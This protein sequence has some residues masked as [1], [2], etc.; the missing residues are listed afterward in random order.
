[1]G[2]YVG[3]KLGKY[4]L[5]R[6]LG[7]GS[8]ADVYL[9]RPLPL[10]TEYAVKVL[11]TQMSEDNTSQFFDQAQLIALLEHT[12][13]LRL[14]DF[15]V[16][17]GSPFLVMD[18]APYGTLR[19]RHP[20]G[21][22][23]PLKTILHY[24]KQIAGALQYAHDHELIHL[25][26][27]P[28]NMMLGRRGEVLLSDFGITPI[29]QST[30]L[31]K[32][33]LVTGTAAYMSPEQF[34]GKVCFA[35]DQYALGIVV[36]EWLSGKCPFRGSFSEVASQ[37]WSALPPSLP[38]TD[39]TVP[40]AVEDVVM[41]AL[42][43]D[44]GQRFESVQDFARALTEAGSSISSLA[45]VSTDAPTFPLLP[46]ITAASS[47]VPQPLHARSQ[48]PDLPTAS[49]PSGI[50][51]ITTSPTET[52][53]HTPSM[54]FTASTHVGQLAHY[55]Q[56]RPDTHR[57]PIHP[58]SQQAGKFSA[59]WHQLFHS[60]KAASAVLLMILAIVIIAGALTAYVVKLDKTTQESPAP[61][62]IGVSQ[63]P[64]GEY[65]GI[66]DGT[67]AFDTNRADG[68]SKRE[69]ADKLKV[70][71]ITTAESL[72]QIGIQHDANDAEALIYQEDQQVLS[73]DHPHITLVVGTVLT[74]TTFGIGTGREELQG[75]YIAQKEFNDHAKL[76]G[77]IQV[78]LLIANSGNQ[79]EYATRVA[80]QIVQ[81]ARVD[82]TIVGVM[83]WP[84]NASSAKAID[85]LEASHIPMISPTAYD[86]SL[87]GISPYFFRVVPP[88]QRQAV[89]GAQF[90]E[91]RFHSKRGAL[92]VDPT[93]TYSKN[94]AA[95]FEQQFV[96]DGN[97]IA[98]TEKYTVGQPETLPGLLQN[99]LGA[100][101]DLIYFAGYADD[102]G[103][104]LAHLPTSGPFANIQ[105]LGGEALYGDYHE[106]TGANL[107]R[108]HFTASAYS[109]EWD[110]LN[111]SAKKPP[112]FT[113]FEQDFP[114]EQTAGG[115]STHMSTVAMLSFDATF[116]LLTGGSTATSPSDLLE[117]LKKMSG[118][119][120]L[121]GVSGQ[122]SLGLDGN[123]VNKAVLLLGFDSNDNTRMESVMGAFLVGS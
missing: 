40:K 88:L 123:P 83:G 116:A 21:E 106:A 25:D 14:R 54:S 77:G 109:N 35:S 9:G 28:E 19:K 36:Y 73:F 38:E 44:P 104:L 4:H 57:P 50:P 15:D 61:E 23:V 59:S 64:D 90:A 119:H 30:H 103:T 82:K 5:I 85:V 63:A 118:P 42:A 66:S 39:P 49:M 110:A 67:F 81:A 98:V 79:A 43:K 46:A 101:P 41:R 102:T 62:A 13:I 117:N 112:F 80:Q 32:Q 17:Q 11:H 47:T 56:S 107:Q 114:D 48:F 65:I 45:S 10:K 60:K 26:V 6:L 108:L 76:S 1:M 22:A 93:D 52:L 94:L 12:H 95:D 120:A 58:S 86:D 34:R 100:N 72:W 70:H 29:V 75:A 121:Q 55:L 33:Q 24:I 71:D 8:F 68:D 105:V 31:A 113:D 16:H 115:S 122:I 2:N 87:T 99:A 91:R 92:F 78:C 7:H 37:H 97:V 84:F 20:G 111:L 18:Y 89:I 69:A 53:S 51:S 3:Q 96:A 27:K 74:G